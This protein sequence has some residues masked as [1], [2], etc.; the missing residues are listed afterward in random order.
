M[1]SSGWIR[2]L[3]LVALAVAAVAFFVRRKPKPT[4]RAWDNDSAPQRDLGS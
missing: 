1:D 4:K 2:V 3:V